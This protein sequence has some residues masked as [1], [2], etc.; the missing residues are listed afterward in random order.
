MTDQLLAI[1]YNGPIAHVQMNREDKRNSFNVAL[2]E[3][4]NDAALALRKRRDIKV[5]ILSGTAKCFSAGADLTDPLQFDA[6]TTLADKRHYALLGA[7]TA[8]AWEQLPQ[9]TVAAIER[10]AIGGGLGLALACDFRVAGESAFLWVPEVEIGANY[11]WNTV[12]RL[13]SLI[14][15]A[16][17]RRMVLLAQR[18]AAPQAQEWGL[19]DE[20][21][22]DGDTLEKAQ[23]LAATL[24]KMPSMALAVSKRAINV[25]AGALTD[26]SSHGDMEQVLLCFSDWTRE[27]SEI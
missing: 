24:A 2:I 15:P 27:K 19:I 11:G 1:T 22:A 12:P 17:T 6:A 7:E 3:A 13:M 10:Y 9:V 25:V 26:I 16:R 14:G 21:V 23:A 18:I 4:L 8:R 5:I 20:L